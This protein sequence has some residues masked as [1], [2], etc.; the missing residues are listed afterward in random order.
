MD[1]SRTHLLASG[2]PIGSLS[3]AG[4]VSYLHRGS[5][6]LSPVLPLCGHGCVGGHNQ[7]SGVRRSVEEGISSLS[8]QL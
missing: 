6:S 8:F 1:R 2:S 7:T 5:L 4:G 3:V